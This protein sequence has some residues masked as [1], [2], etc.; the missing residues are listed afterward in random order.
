MT[1]NEAGNTEIP[2]NDPI[3]DIA[4][5]EEVPLCPNCLEPVN[6]LLHYCRACGSTDAINPLTT[7]MPWESLRFEYGGYGKLW[8]MIVQR[9]RPAWQT[10]LLVLILLVAAPIAIPLFVVA[11][12]VYRKPLGMRFRWSAIF[13]AAAVTAVAILAWITFRYGWWFRWG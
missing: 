9:R 5:Q 8:R 10:A 6:P 2:E 12:I 3:P 13:T 1:Q 11:A 4:E 7:Y